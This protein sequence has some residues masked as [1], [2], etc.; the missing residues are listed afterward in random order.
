MIFSPG[1]HAQGLQ[2]ELVDHNLHDENKSQDPSGDSVASGSS[3]FGSLP[4]KKRGSVCSTGNP[5][6]EYYI[7]R[8]FK[9]CV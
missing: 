3:G 5:I 6:R 8:C 4:R 2:S 7:T 9:Y 1:V